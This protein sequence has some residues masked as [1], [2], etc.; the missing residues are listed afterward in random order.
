[1][2]ATGGRSDERAAIVRFEWREDDQRQARPLRL[3]KPGRTDFGF[4]VLCGPTF[5]G[6]NRKE[7]RGF[8]VALVERTWS[9]TRGFFLLRRVSCSGSKV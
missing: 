3:L 1:M 9:V 6:F 7:I 5:G 8:D 4:V 2:W